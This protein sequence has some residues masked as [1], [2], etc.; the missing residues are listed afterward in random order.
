MVSDCNMLLA[1]HG[2]CSADAQGTH[3]LA[4]FHGQ[5]LQ[6]TSTQIVIHMSMRSCGLEKDW[7]TA[8]NLYT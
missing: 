1:E 6:A 2:V 4:W 5:A 8:Q 7:S 3:T